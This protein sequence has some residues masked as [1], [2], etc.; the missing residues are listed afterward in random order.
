MLFEPYPV[1][2]IFLPRYGK[3]HNKHDNLSRTRERV[4]MLTARFLAP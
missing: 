4:T 2:V 3:N 1:V